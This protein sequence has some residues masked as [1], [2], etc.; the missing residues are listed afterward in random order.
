M[1][2]S[3]RRGRMVLLSAVSLYCLMHNP[4]SN[5]A[6]APEH[7]ALLLKAKNNAFY[8]AI[9]LGVK[10][11]AAKYGMTVEVH[12][13]HNE[14]DWQSQVS[15][16]HERMRDFDGFIVV[17]N[18]SDQFAA[19]MAELAQNKKP[20]IIVDTPL[21][22]GNADATITVSSDN[23]LGGR[24]AGLFI[25]NQLQ[26]H[27]NAYPCL[28][29]LS[30]NPQAKTHQDRNAGFLEALRSKYSDLPVHTFIGMSSYEEAQQQTQQHLA[31]IQRCG[32]VFAGSDTMIL[33]VVSAF[34]DRHLPLPELLVGYDAILAVQQKIMRGLVSASVQ[35]F[36]AEMGRAA[37]EAIQGYARG[38][39]ME[40]SRL[41]PPKLVVRQFHIDTVPES[42]LA[43]AESTR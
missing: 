11:R 17:P 13:G 23:V 39:P 43:D 6:A 21:T 5:W 16:L 20:A 1:W 28:I 15:F 38:E 3:L 8:D 41:I 14:D 9:L 33:G 24:L 32:A 25:A 26:E 18:R 29:L 7:I 42:K 19:V 2:W 36:P 40:K 27:P 4:Q 35:Q 10:E 37:V 12:Y 22:Q 30:G 34:Q 31:Q